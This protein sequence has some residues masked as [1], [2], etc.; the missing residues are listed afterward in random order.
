MAIVMQ[1]KPSKSNFLFP[2]SWQTLLVLLTL[3]FLYLPILVMAIYSFNASASTAQWTGL[4]LDWYRR[5]FQDQRM[6]VAL[7]TSL[8][9]A[10]AAVSMAAVIGTLMAVG[11][12]RYRF[13]G[14][15][16]Y[17]TVAYLPPIVPDI[18]MGVATLVAL[19]TLA[20]PL[21][22]WTIVAAHGV[23]CLAYI[24]VTIGTRIGDLDPHLEE[25]ALDLG[26]TPFQAF[27]QV[28]LP[29]LSPAIFS[30]CLLAFALSMDDLVIS[31]FTA[32]GGATTLP[33]E[34]FSRIRRVVKP[35]LNALSVFL[36]LVS[37]GAAI[38]AEVIRLRG[39]S[40]RG[41]K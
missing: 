3:G 7:W 29:Q 38:L 17:Q 36:L 37:G 25:A 11:L 30:G 24:A 27:I 41:V 40:Q 5:A 10:I 8:R 14:K 4:T 20:I 21:S 32:G 23:F 12:A 35:D 1:A 2:F 22:F 18:T 33:M 34:I 28:L 19:A 39:E 13:R 31:S 6:M 16:I 9:V 26:A 15:V